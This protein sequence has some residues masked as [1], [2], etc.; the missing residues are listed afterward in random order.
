MEA[1][2]T[3]YKLGKMFMRRHF[4]GT[5]FPLVVPTTA[6]LL[7]FFFMRCKIWLLRI[8]AGRLKPA[9]VLSQPHPPPTHVLFIFT[10][11]LTLRY[12]IK[13]NVLT[14]L[15][16]TDR[17]RTRRSSARPRTSRSPATPWASIPRSGPR[18]RPWRT[19]PA[20]ARPPGWCA[21]PSAQGRAAGTACRPAR[22]PSSWPRSSSC[23]RRR[24]CPRP[25][26][27]TRRRRPAAAPA[28]RLGATRSARTPGRRP[29][30]PPTPPKRTVPPWTC[31]HG[32]RGSVSDAGPVAAVP[33][34]REPVVTGDFSPNRPWNV[35]GGAKTR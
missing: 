1:R 16:C 2:K 3:R 18:S 35:I 11:T 5:R 12:T 19:Q 17:W 31:G 15:T 22:C 4:D 10:E 13:R 14:T 9:R 26:T 24:R 34:Q 27:A 32:A 29:P 7:D 20:R 28:P 30:P 6:I 33:R 8:R 23:R 21:S 25:A